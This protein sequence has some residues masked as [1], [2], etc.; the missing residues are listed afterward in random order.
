MLHIR[1]DSQPEGKRA[2]RTR[3]GGRGVYTPKEDICAMR[4]VRETAWAQ[5]P[6]GGPG[7][8]PIGVVIVTRTKRTKALLSGRWGRILETLWS[9]VKPDADNISKLYLDGLT[10]RKCPSGL[11]MWM[12]D[13]AQVSL[14]CVQKLRC[15]IGE[16]PR[17]DLYVWRIRSS[18]KE[19]QILRELVSMTQSPE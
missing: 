5:H 4:H 14:L 18:P 12:A 16:E 9:K 11:P 13:D 1:I 19:N 6:E 17:V 10:R 8:G 7:D 3:F 2:K 15:A